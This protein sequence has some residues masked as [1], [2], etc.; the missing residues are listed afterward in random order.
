MPHACDYPERDTPRWK[1]TARFLRRTRRRYAFARFGCPLSPANKLRGILFASLRK[2]N[3][4]RQPGDA[5]VWNGAKTGC[6]AKRSVS[7][8][9]RETHI[10]TVLT[11]F[12][13]PS[14]QSSFVVRGPIQ[15]GSRRN[16]GHNLRTKLLAHRRCS[17]RSARDISIKTE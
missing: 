3:A 11:H 16:V 5:A 10:W 1:K 8:H 15:M 4:Q 6:A 9:S 2:W 12:A 14:V 13:L 17:K 7:L